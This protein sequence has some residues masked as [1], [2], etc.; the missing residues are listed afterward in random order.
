M[1]LRQ[2]RIFAT[3]AHI[4]NFTKSAEELDYAQSNITAQIKLLEE[5]LGCKLFERLGKKVTLTNEGKALLPYA[6]Q[7]LKLSSEAK[8]AASESIQLKGTLTVGVAESLCVF[9]LPS[10]FKQFCKLYYPNVKLIL[11]LG[12]PRD[13]HH[14]LRD[15]TVDVAF[16]LDKEI[17]DPDLISQTLHN[18][19]VVMVGDPEHPLHARG[20]ITPQD[21]ANQTLI[22]TECHCSYRAALEK[23]LE[24]HNVSPASSMEFGS[25]EAIKQF[26]ASGLGVAL[27]PEAAVAKELSQ[28]KLVNLNWTGPEINVYTQLVY[29]KDKWLSPT[30]IAMLELVNKHSRAG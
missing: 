10:L 27:L 5:E 15:N 17:T 1:E 18:E 11:K 4:L 28:G 21:L 20:Q 16:F 22:L 13:F 23:I 3:V 29:H 26:V 2:L 9:R 12:T 14:W 19:P 6:N 25:V 24:E 7:I 30:L 8:H